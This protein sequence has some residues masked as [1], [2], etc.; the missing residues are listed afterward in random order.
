MNVLLIRPQPPAETIGLQ[1]VMICEP[2]ELEYVA[3]NI[4][5]P[6]ANITILDMILEKKPLAYFL[7]RYQ[8]DVVGLTGYITHIQVIK[9]YARQIKTLFPQCLVVVS[10]V[11]AEVLPQDLA[12]PA[13]D[14]VLESHTLT[15][16]NQLLHQWQRHRLTATDQALFESQAPDPSKN[17]KSSLEI[18]QNKQGDDHWSKPQCIEQLTQHIK[19]VYQPGSRQ[20]KESSFDHAFPHRR[21]TA[22]YRSRYYY[23]FHRPCALMKT[24]FG[25]PYQCTFCFCRHIT[26][27]EY[28]TRPLNEVLDELEQIDEEEIYIV[29]DDFLASKERVLA[30]CQGLD[31]RELHKKFLVYGRA[32]FIARNPEV[33]QEFRQR[34]LQAVIVGL[35][36][37]R[38]EDLDHYHKQT[39][40]QENEAAV[41][42]LQQYEVA[43]YA[44]M[45]LDP[46]FTVDDFKRLGTWLKKLDLIFVNLQPLTPLPGT[47]LYET[48]KDKL[49]VPVADVA[50]WD[51]AHLVVRP[52]HMSVRQYYVQL[53]SLYFM[54]TLRPKNMMSM[55]R[56]YGL[57]ATLSLSIGS[58][59]ITR[60]YIGKILKG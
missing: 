25:C 11:H 51:L 6:E 15:A 31:Q 22:R 34:G 56:Q 9:N 21:L 52:G 30:F 12:D 53:L 1:H 10:G 33:I 38:E 2:L 16:F 19:G 20:P 37:A 5:L 41:H 50:K 44:T 55:I 3:A 4:D 26:G 7:K 47:P 8:P 60:Q 48:Y 18:H 54:I 28:Y 29:D 36:S 13:I 27:D 49:M 40:L 39:S 24:S 58:S 59:H 42:I 14:V 32:D 57:K 23:M 43:V 17:N 46:D 35:E 45:I